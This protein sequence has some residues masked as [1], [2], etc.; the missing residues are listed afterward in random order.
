MAVTDMS[1]AA[2]LTLVLHYVMD[3]SVK[4]RLSDV[5][6]LLVASKLM[7]LL[8]L[9]SVSLKERMSVSKLMTG[10]LCLDKVVAQWSDGAWSCQLD[11]MGVQAKIKERAPMALFIHCYAHRLYL[12]LTQGAL[13][14]KDLFCPHQWPR[15]IFLQVLSAHATTGRNLPAASCS[16]GKRTKHLMHKF[17]HS[18]FLQYCRTN[19]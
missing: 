11:Q 3:T 5:E 6:M 4:D 13:K 1:Y 7:T 16:C 19:H 2:Q 10:T 17:A 14:L 18:W 12:V 9:S 15:C 8:A